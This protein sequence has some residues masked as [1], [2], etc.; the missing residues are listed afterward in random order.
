[1]RVAEVS[2]ELAEVKDVLSA[3]TKGYVLCTHC[4]RNDTL[5][6]SMAVGVEGGIVI[7]DRDGM[8]RLTGPIGVYCMSCIGT[9]GE[10]KSG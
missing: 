7:A 2:G 8:G 4:V 5:A 1:M 3:A 9:C 6:L 10:D